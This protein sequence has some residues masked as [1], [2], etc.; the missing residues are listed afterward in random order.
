M[1][2]ISSLCCTHIE[3]ARLLFTHRSLFPLFIACPTQSTIIIS[4][5]DYFSEDQK[6]YTKNTNKHNTNKKDY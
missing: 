5:D 1:S 4:Q 2:R 6:S 3:N